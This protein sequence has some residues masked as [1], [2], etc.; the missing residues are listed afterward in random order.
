MHKTVPP[1][2]QADGDE[3][4]REQDPQACA[5][6]DTHS[7]RL[8]RELDQLLQELRSIIPG[9]QVMYAFLLTVAFTERFRSLTDLQRGV[10]YALLLIGGIS[11]I[12]LLAPSA[13][14][15]VRF[16]QGDKEAMIKAA[17]VEVIA[18]L[19]LI[20]LSIAGVVF[21]ISDLMFS[22]PV[23]LVAGVAVWLIAAALWWGFPL[24]RTVTTDD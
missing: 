2:A 14:H 20:S 22:T 11:L 17:N 1:T 5:A 7:E 12:L 18:A 10:Y 4:S 13:F 3:V 6:A 15:R 21:L 19:V 9:V 23:A 16:R 8:E 24:G